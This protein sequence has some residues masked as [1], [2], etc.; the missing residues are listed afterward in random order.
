MTSRRMLLDEIKPILDDYVSN[1]LPDGA[2]FQM[3]IDVL[4][5]HFA[6]KR[7]RPSIDTH[8]LVL[9]YLRDRAANHLKGNQNA[10]TV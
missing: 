10:K 4:D 8:D 2:W 7:I 5:Q 1:D 9:D 3:M 6:K